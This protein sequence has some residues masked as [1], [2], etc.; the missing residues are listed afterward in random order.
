MKIYDISQEVFSCQVYPDDPAPKKNKLKSIE[1][2]E[3]YNL[4]EFSMCAHNG[5]HIDAPSHFIKDGKTVDEICLESFVGKAFVIEHQGIV[6]DKDAVEILKKAKKQDEESAKRILIKGDAE[7]SL[8]AAKVFA[9]SGILLLGNE[10][11]TI[12]PENAPMNVHI[13]LLNANVVLLEGI[14]LSLVSEGVYFLN[15]APLNL[16]GTDGS[17]C[18]AILIS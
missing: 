17:P 8:D 6:T 15:A 16:Q 4:T 14:R 2:G 1:D 10:S 5:T 13:A 18:R 11:Q 9:S 3:L 12:G 7:V